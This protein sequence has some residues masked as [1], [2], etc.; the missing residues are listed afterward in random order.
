MTR[1]EIYRSRERV[2]ERGH[3]PGFYVVVSRSF[4]AENED[5]S[6]IICAPVYS[7][8]LGLCSEVVLGPGEGLPRNCAARCDFLMLLFKEKLT[9][10]VGSLSPD[11]LLELDRALVCALDIQSADEQ[12]QGN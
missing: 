7:E 2:P 11:K 1:G 4:I 8:I 9:G 6:T 12:L 3:K 5:V 10:F